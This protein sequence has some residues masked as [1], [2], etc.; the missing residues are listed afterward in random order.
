MRLLKRAEWLGDPWAR[1]REASPL[2]RSYAGHELDSVQ[3]GEP[4]A[5]FKPMPGVGSGVMEFRLHV[6][7]HFFLKKTQAT[8]KADLDQGRK[9]CGVTGIEQIEMK[10]LTTKTINGLEFTQGSGDMFADLGFSPAEARNLHL[11]SQMM[12]ALK[13]LIESHRL[14]Q[15]DAAKRL[16]VSQ[17]RISDLIRGKIHLFSLDTLVNMLVA[18]GLEVDVRIKAPSRRVA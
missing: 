11:R 12:R 2:V 1:L 9:L 14:T 7:T 6:G 8:G 18:A 3:R 15:T 4:P 16:H 13:K 17:P 5:D 10:K